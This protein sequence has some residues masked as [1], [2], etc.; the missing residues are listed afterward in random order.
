[1][2]ENDVVASFLARLLD[3]TTRERS[4]ASSLGS[5]LLQL[6]LLLPLLCMQ[7]LKPEITDLLDHLQQEM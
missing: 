4:F 2:L 1:M 3:A 5:H 6:L 7:S